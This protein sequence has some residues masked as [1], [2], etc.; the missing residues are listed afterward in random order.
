MSKYVNDKERF[1]VAVKSASIRREADRKSPTR[2]RTEDLGGAKLRL[3]VNGSVEGYHL[4]WENDEDGAI[5]R[6]LHEGFDFVSQAEVNMEKA[7]VGDAD[8]GDRIS[9][10]V[11]RLSDGSPQRAYLLKCP[12]EIWKKRVDARYAEADSRERDIRTRGANTREGQYV[13]QGGGA[14]LQTNSRIN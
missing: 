1:D 3:S 2:E 6:L 4:Y 13:P 12:D 10:Y 9:R 14:N 5:E 7:V 11:G 8:L